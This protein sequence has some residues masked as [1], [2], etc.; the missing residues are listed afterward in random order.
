MNWYEVTVSTNKEDMDDV[1]EILLDQG[2]G[3]VTV[4]DPEEVRDRLEN[5]L[6][7]D[8]VGEDLVEFIPKR[9]SIKAYF[10]IDSDID[11]II[12][13]VNKR[14]NGICRGENDV[15]VKL[16]ND[17]KWNSWKEYFK[18]FQLIDNVTVVPSWEVYHSSPDEKIIMMDPGMAFGTGTHETTRLCAQLIYR[19]VSKDDTFLDLG[20]GTGI[21]SV[22]AHLKGAGKITAVDIDDAA[23]RAA[24]ENF[25]VNGIKI[26]SFES[27]TDEIEVI[28]GTLDSVKG[29]RFHVIAANILAEVLIDLAPDMK[30]I[31]KYPGFVI[32]SGIIQ[33]KE[34]EVKD[35][36]NQNG[37]HHLETIKENDWVAMVFQWQDFM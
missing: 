28:K 24:K 1:S 2:C 5:P 32:L 27:R 16:V 37:F 26:Q 4:E 6:P 12:S 18:P 7:L 13:E 19:Y 8:Y 15:F 29:R 33:K 20:T 10:C 31:V 21:L 34:Q 30:H 25:E 36:F 23:V 11:L 22:I 35:A 14:I 3:G 9:Y 17:E